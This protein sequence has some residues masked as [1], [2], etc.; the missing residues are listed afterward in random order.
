MNV[1]T[2][3][4]PTQIAVGEYILDIDYDYRN[5]MTI[6]LAMED[7]YLTNEEKAF[8]LL[9]RLYIDLPDDVDIMLAFK[10]GIRFLDGGEEQEQSITPKKSKPRVY[11]FDKD[12]KYIFTAVDR[13]LDGKVSNNS[14]IHWW[15]FTMAFMECPEDSMFSRIVHLRTQKLKGKLTK[16]ERHTWNQMRDIL[17]LEQSTDF[18]DEQEQE[19]AT[20]NMKSFME[21]EIERR[22]RAKNEPGKS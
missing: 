3:S 14:K 11:S 4:L 5:C 13:V 10:Q 18:K 16:E 20:V 17:E 19:Q 21:Q 9:D 2:D 8:V 6:I 12:S 22:K 15:L 1:L 7:Q